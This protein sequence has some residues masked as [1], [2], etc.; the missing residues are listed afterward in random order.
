MLEVAS[1]ESV[2][3]HCKS[4]WTQSTVGIVGT[5]VTALVSM[6]Y[7][8]DPSRSERSTVASGPVYLTCF[9]EA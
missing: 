5:V 7:I 3:A 9:K 6:L 8:W 2:T 4:K 1:P